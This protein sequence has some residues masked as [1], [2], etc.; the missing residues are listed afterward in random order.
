MSIFFVKFYT[1]SFGGGGWRVFIGDA[2]GTPAGND[3]R[4]GDLALMFA[5]R[6]PD[7]TSAVTMPAGWKHLPK[8]VFPHD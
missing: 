8:I 1:G 2:N 5:A 6:A 7:N 3:V 4:E